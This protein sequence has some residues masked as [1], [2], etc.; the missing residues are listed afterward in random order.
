M[1]TP[2]HE[3]VAHLAHQL[4]QEAGCP[5]GRDLEIWLEAERKLG[6]GSEAS[7]ADEVVHTRRHS[8][9][10]TEQR[11]AAREPITPHTSAPAAKPAETGK[12]LW[13]RP[14]SR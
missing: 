6:A 13:D 5:A 9:I 4:W 12:P 14:H 11:H 1:K 2:T 10:T 7:G 3:E 8:E